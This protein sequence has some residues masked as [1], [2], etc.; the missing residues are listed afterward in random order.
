M[1]SFI[2]LALSVVLA[3]TFAS[4]NKSTESINKEARRFVS[5]RG[6][7]ACNLLFD[8]VDVFQLF[9][10]KYYDTAPDD[11]LESLCSCTAE[12]CVIYSGEESFVQDL[13]G[14]DNISRYG[15][16]FGNASMIEQMTMFPE[17]NKKKKVIN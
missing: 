16:L 11:Y 15:S 17:W 1:R 14:M 13:A 12:Q 2:T 3:I 8:S 7:Y 6:D 10:E 9:P 5:A 4:C